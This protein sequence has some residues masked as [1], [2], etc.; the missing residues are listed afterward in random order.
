MRLALV[1]AALLLSLTACGARQPAA[2]PPTTSAATTETVPQDAPAPGAAAALEP[3]ADG[4]V[5]MSD[6]EW[7]QRLTPEQYR[8]VREAG[9]ERAGTGALLHNKADGVYRCVACDLALFDSSAKFKSGTGWPSFFEPIAAIALD[10]GPMKTTPA[11][12]ATRANRA[13]SARNPYPGWIA[14]APISRASSTISS[15]LR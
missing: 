6:A 15:A 4:K 5:E 2:A 9:T 8:I 14:S 3:N 13:F 12:S 11:S 10:G 1:L 7:R